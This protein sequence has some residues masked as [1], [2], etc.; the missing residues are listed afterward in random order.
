MN[1]SSALPTR[2][3]GSGA[4]A[5]AIT[6]IIVWVINAFTGVEIPPEV[7]SA[8][9]LVLMF[10]ASYFVPEAEGDVP[11]PITPIPPVEPEQPIPAAPI[12][13]TEPVAQEPVVP[14]TAPPDETEVSPAAPETPAAA[15]PEPEI[16][17]ATSPDSSTRQPSPPPQSQR[18]KKPGQ[19]KPR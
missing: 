12:P 7:S 4:L 14:D 11:V 9:T 2:K 6:V 3:V 1:Q 19:N 16:P 18:D 5:G 8:I 15:T 17:Q 10:G 13:P